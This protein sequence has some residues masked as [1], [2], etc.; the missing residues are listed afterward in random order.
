ML[1]KCHS[2]RPDPE[3]SEGEGTRGISIGDASGFALSMTLYFLFFISFAYAKEMKKPEPRLH[4][5][6][7]RHSQDLATNLITLEG[8]VEVRYENNLLEAGKVVIDKNKN[9]AVA[10][11]NVRLYIPSEFTEIKAHEIHFNY[12]DRTG[13]FISA[14]VKSGYTRLVGKKIFKLGEKQYEMRNGFFS[15]CDVKEGESCPWKIWS[16]RTKVTLGDYATATHPVFLAE[17]FPI[18]YSPFIFFPVK[19]ERQ[20]GLLLPDFGVSDVSGFRLK[21]MLFLA[22]GRSHDVTLGLEYL[23]KRGLKPDLEYRYVIDDRSSG[24][25][26]A[27]F[28]RDREFFGDFGKRDRFAVDYNHKLYFYPN[29]FNKADIQLISDRDYVKDFD[30]DVGGR[31]DPGLEAKLLQGYNLENISF[32]LEGIIYQDLL[33]PFPRDSNQGITHKLPEFKVVVH[34]TRYFGLPFLFGSDL[35][36]VNFRNEGDDFIDK[37][38]DQIYNEGVDELKRAQRLDVFPRISWPVTVKPYF[39]WIPVLGFQETHWWIPTGDR[40]KNRQMLDILQTLKTNIG[41]IFHIG[42]KKIQKIK[43][44]IEPS[45]SYHYLPFIR[46]DRGLPDFDGIDTIKNTNLIGWSLQ[47]RLVFKGIDG[48]T[49]YYFDG[50]RLAASQNFN[51]IEQRKEDEPRRPFSSVSTVLSSQLSHFILSMEA[52]LPVYGDRRLSRLSNQIQ[53]QDPFL[54]SYRINYTFTDPAEQ[55]SIGALI[56]LNFIKVLKLKFLL[57]YSFD[58]DIFLEKV[59]KA[60]YYPT[61]KCWA[62]NMTFSD[63]LDKGFSFNVGVNLL[64]GDNL[65]SFAGLKQEGELKRLRL[66]PKNEIDPTLTNAAPY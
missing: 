22:L 17:G 60:I 53:Y 44:I 19:K 35:S 50:L 36:Y 12:K 43:H 27:Y 38:G 31:E 46:I 56:D 37:N 20:S 33:S 51:M 34:H 18:F 57:N 58:R 21:N 15:T 11:D 16:H 28:I 30:L 62:L 3:R 10:T 25:L 23:S 59:Y 47:N 6:A 32:N 5:K 39:E 2:E 9:M 7:V 63:A 64:F 14:H 29:F 45:V 1:K 24:M 13:V 41:R 42:G 26:N 65:L 55:N 61:S 66:F 4:F 40:N 52:D 54:N 49:P 48:T 8:H